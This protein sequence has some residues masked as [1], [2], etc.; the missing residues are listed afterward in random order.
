MP[1]G[2]QRNPCHREIVRIYTKSGDKGQTGLFSGERVSKTHPRVEAYGTLD[3]M[4][5]H[6]GVVRSLR[7]AGPV[8]EK[9]DFL[10]R[11]VFELG[12]D[13]ATVPAPDTQPRIR[14]EHVKWLES[15]IDEMTAAVPPLRA[16]ILPGGS[17]AAAHLHVAR[18]VCRRAERAALLAAATETIPKPALVFLNRLSDFLFALARYEN[19]LSGVSERE[20]KPLDG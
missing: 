16:F 1:L 17:P 11:L 7:P 4:N 9:L 5:S 6:L 3:E 2:R 19:A 13:L 15:G 20:W 18:C 10:Q 14:D 12:S 8:D